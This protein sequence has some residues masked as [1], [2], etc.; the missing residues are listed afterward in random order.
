MKNAPQV[1]KGMRIEAGMG[2][3]VV[4]GLGGMES[5]MTEKERLSAMTS[6]ERARMGCIETACA[7]ANAAGE[8]IVPEVAVRDGARRGEA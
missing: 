5:G 1:F 7:F 4:E 3:R 8:R 6:R 2:G